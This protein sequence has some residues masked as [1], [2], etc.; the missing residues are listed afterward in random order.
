MVIN[1]WH[2]FYL[3]LTI[4]AQE[5]RETL[6]VLHYSYLNRIRLLSFHFPATMEPVSC[7]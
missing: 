2:Q 6:K 4:G 1:C 7:V 5:G 3:Q